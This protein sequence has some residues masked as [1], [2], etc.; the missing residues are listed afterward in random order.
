[1]MSAVSVLAVL[2]N[3]SRLDILYI[4]TVFIDRCLMTTQ[5]QYR[6]HFKHVNRTCPGW[7]LRVWGWL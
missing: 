7:M 4:K 2:Y 3:W 5:Q 1:M 6:E